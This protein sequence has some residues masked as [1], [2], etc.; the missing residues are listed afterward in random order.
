MASGTVRFPQEFPYGRP[1]PLDSPELNTSMLK[2]LAMEWCLH[3]ACAKED[4]LVI[5]K[6]KVN[7]EGNESGC[8]GPS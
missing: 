7:E 1:L 8:P 5:L 6:D 3:T 2:R 4:L